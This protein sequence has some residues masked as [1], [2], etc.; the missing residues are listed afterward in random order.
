[1]FEC[2][3]CNNV[4]ESFAWLTDR[5]AHKCRRR[6]CQ[7]KFKN[8]IS[9]QRLASYRDFWECCDRQI[10]FP[11]LWQKVAEV[12]T[13]WLHWSSKD[14]GGAIKHTPRL[15]FWISGL[16]AEKIQS[17]NPATTPTLKNN[18]L[19]LKGL[20]RRSFRCEK[21]VAKHGEPPPRA[22]FDSGKSNCNMIP[23]NK[24]SP[25][26]AFRRGEERQRAG[27]CISGSHLNEN[28]NGSRTFPL[29]LA[30]VQACLL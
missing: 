15:P 19:S 27:R 24:G 21:H 25:L 18:Q 30:P 16:M 6:W 1:M 8:G 2:T 26:N 29:M 10:P 5:A 20:I 11:V 9:R 7:S 23:F 12:G 3:L 13:V 28:W 22:F 4:D 14:S 17:R